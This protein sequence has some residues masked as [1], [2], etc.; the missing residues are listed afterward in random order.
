LRAGLTLRNYGCFLDLSHQYLFRLPAG[1]AKNLCPVAYATKAALI[2]NIDRYFRGYDNAFPDYYRECEWEREF[3]KFSKNGDLP[4][5]ELVRLMH[6]HMG[7]FDKAIDR[8]NTPELEQ[9]DNDSAYWAKKTATFDF[10]KEDNLGDP[11]RFNRIIWEGL[12]GNLPYPSETTG[13]DLRKPRRQ[14]P[15]RTGAALED[16]K[17]EDN[18]K[19]TSRR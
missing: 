14:I 19:I 12:K 17:I 18:E 11:E 6:D 16:S 8:V 13:T 1:P 5:L 4:S 2:A 10:T 7:D 9:A 15:K 3:A